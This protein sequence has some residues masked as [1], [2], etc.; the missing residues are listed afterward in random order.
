MHPGWLFRVNGED[1]QLMIRPAIETNNGDTATQLAVAGAGIAR[2]GLFNVADKIA[3]GRLVE[4]LTAY[5]PQDIEPFHALYL[6]GATLPARVRV[7][8]DFLPKSSPEQRGA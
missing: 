1:I 5:C 6:G 4:I 7:F 2:V 3:A 8:I